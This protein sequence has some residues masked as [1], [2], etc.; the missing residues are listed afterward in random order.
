M[1]RLLTV[2]LAVA[3]LASLPAHAQL[4]AAASGANLRYTLEDLAP[5]DGIAAAAVL[6]AGHA[7][8]RESLTLY[9]DGAP[10]QYEG[11]E[12]A[13]TAPWTIAHDTSY[14]HTGVALLDKGTVVAATLAPEFG[15]TVIAKQNVNAIQ[16]FSLAPHTSITFLLDAAADL[17]VD[18]NYPA[19]QEANA[20]IDLYV[21]GLTWSPQPVGQSGGYALGGSVSNDPENRFLGFR[22]LSQSSGELRGT[23]TNTTDDWLDGRVMVGSTLFA[24][25][26]NAADVSPIPEPGEWAMLGVGCALLGTWGRRKKRRS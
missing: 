18:V 26:R 15:T 13:V 12:H 24:W 20:S 6:G 17:Q 11:G 4:R 23:W 9:P 2:L 14:G 1:P 22:P 19:V 21:D 7:D 8:I 5:S 10:A 16:E 3:G 25:A